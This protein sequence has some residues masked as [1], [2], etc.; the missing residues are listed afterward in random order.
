MTNLQKQ[1]IEAMRSVGKSYT[2]IAEEL[3]LPLNTIKSH[4][5]RKGLGDGYIVKQTLHRE[6]GVCPNCGSPLTQTPGK[7]RK[8]FCSDKCRSEWW[9]KHPEAI[10]RKAIYRFTCVI[11]HKE[12]SSYGNANRKFCSRACYGRSRSLNHD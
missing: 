12:F 11:C 1:Q 4:C 9:A 6:D 8:K 5:R 3:H 7:K 10:H 2:S